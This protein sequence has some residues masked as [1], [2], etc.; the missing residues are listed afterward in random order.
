MF[1][2]VTADQ[3]GKE[4]V[5]EYNTV[6]LAI[7]RDACTSSIGLDKAGVKVNPKSGKLDCKAEQTNVTNIYAIGDV[8]DGRPELTPVGSSSSS[9]GLTVF[10]RAC[11]PSLAKI[12]ARIK[13]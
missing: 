13:A 1:L 4:V 12:Q 8:L 5:E 10:S 3:G 7:G 6:L 2:Q 11:P 9:L